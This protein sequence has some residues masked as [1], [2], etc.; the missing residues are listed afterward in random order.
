MTNEQL[1][2]HL[3]AQ[4]FQAFRVHLADGRSV[5][6]KHPDYVAHGG[7]RTFVVFTSEEQVETIDILLVTSLETINGN[8]RRGRRL[9]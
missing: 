8:R 2:R 6:V 9:E 3:R 5:H 7:G 4:P 1:Q